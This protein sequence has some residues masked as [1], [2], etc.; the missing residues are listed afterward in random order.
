MP[1]REEIEAEA[2]ERRREKALN[3][4]YRAAMKEMS[5]RAVRNI[6][7]IHGLPEDAL[8]GLP[9]HEVLARVKMLN[10]AR[11]LEGKPVEERERILR[12]LER[13][14]EEPGEA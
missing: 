4:E 11:A 3:E 13:E 5:A 14:S 7:R 10:L 8:D 12:E 1:R 6:L 9:P 2:E